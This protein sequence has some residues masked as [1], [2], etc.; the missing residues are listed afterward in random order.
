M[1]LR[2]KR[3]TAAPASSAE[4]YFTALGEAYSAAASP[5]ACDEVALAVGGTV[6][7]VS[8]ASSAM[9][10]AFM[11]ALERLRVPA[12]PASAR[13]AVWDTTSSGIPVPPFPWS[14]GDVGPGGTV[15]RI[16]GGRYRTL[17]RDEVRGFHSLAVCDLERLSGY[18]WY[19]SHERI[20]WYERAEPLR[21]FIH[22]ML[23]S[24]TRYLAHAS[25]VGDERGALLLTGSG[26]AGK[27][28]T[29]LASIDAGLCFVADNYLLISLENEPI[30]HGLYGTAKLWPQTLTRLPHLAPYVR[31]L[32]VA[33]DEKLVVDVARY[34]P[35]SI[36]QQLPVKAVVVPEVK[37]A[38]ETRV[39]RCTPIDAL[40]ALA[41]T[42]IFQLPRTDRGLAG[43]SALVRRLPT[44]KLKLGEDLM[45]GPAALSALLDELNSDS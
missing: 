40:L 38:S 31:T 16:D 7:G 19:D 41:P 6:L 28:T 1:P 24:S 3:D 34:R 45:S 37:P 25:A 15:A 42:T 4:Q 44:Y 14:P 5:A 27:T 36:A 9:A 20:H 33:T 13:V 2:E 12:M 39:E 43:M 11:P 22:W 32:K 21:A 35:Q 29:A 26:G 23:T 10:D 17:Y 8:F 18:L 30:A